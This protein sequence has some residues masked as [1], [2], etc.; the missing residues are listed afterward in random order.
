MLEMVLSFQ[1]ENGIT[2]VQYPDNRNFNLEGPPEGFQI[3]DTR[4]VETDK[5]SVFLRKK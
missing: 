1:A 2:I 5:F 3:I 4:Q